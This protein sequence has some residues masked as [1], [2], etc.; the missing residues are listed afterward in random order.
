MSQGTRKETGNEVGRQGPG[1]E[2]GRKQETRIAGCRDREVGKMQGDRGD[3]E[4]TVC[5]GWQGG[6]QGVR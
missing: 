4:A 6:R 3:R 5:D 1:K 2:A